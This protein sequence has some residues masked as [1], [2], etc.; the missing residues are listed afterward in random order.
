MNILHVIIGL[1]KGGAET[2]LYNIVKNRQEERLQYRVFSFGCG[3][4]YLP[5]LLDLNITVI[6][7]D[8]RK[9]PVKLIIKLI[10][11][12]EAADMLCSWMYH[13]NILTFLLNIVTCRKPIIWNIRHSNLDK[14]VNKKKTLIIAKLCAL[15]SQY[16]NKIIYNGQLSKN[17]HIKIGY[18]D[19]NSYVLGNGCDIKRYFFHEGARTAF[20]LKYNIKTTNKIV[21]ST[22]KWHPIKDVPCFLNAFK[23]VSSTH[24]NVVAVLCGKG[25]D[26]NNEELCSLID[27][28]HLVIDK[29]IFL[30][31]E[32]NDLEEV[33]SVCDLYVLHS[34]GEAFPN[35]LIEAMACECECISTNVGDVSAI[36]PDGDSIVE[37]S[38]YLGL[39]KLMEFKIQNCS[40]NS[41]NR[42]RVLENYT[43]DS[44]VVKYETTF[45]DLFSLIIL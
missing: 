8:I 10:R 25:N 35:S 19:L 7:V 23:I 2:M 27:K 18:S 17:N 30:L 39:A 14:D 4:Y 34:L 32:R 45:L 24:D 12:M 22:S 20:N 3:D 6:N 40:R 13:A 11:E 43:I 41:Q 26:K 33:Y 29:D 36:L 16:V 42:K 1:G 28:L 9:H 5:L 15:F 38:D 31:G 44:I 21:L 37:A